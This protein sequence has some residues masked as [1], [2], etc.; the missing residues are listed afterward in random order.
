MVYDL[1]VNGQQQGIAKTK[2]K[3][4]KAVEA[5]WLQLSQKTI[6]YEQCMGP[7]AKNSKWKPTRVI[8]PTRLQDHV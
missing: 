4:S 2:V 8:N 1:A 5:S 7:S 6:T 3:K